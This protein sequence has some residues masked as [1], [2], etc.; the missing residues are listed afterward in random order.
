[1]KDRT[2]ATY[3]STSVTAGILTLISGN[4]I[5]MVM[6]SLQLQEINSLSY[7]NSDTSLIKDTT[8][9]T[10]YSHLHTLFG[11]PLQSLVDQ[12]KINRYTSFYRNKKGFRRL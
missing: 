6:S 7:I 8:E 5:S 3:I 11:S 9:A 12:N 2:T 1:M 10:K 4:S